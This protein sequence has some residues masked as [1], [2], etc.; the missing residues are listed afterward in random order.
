MRPRKKLN[1]AVLLRVFAILS[2]VIGHSII[3]YSNEWNWYDMTLESPFLNGLKAFINIFQMPLFISLSGY[4]FYY[5]KIENGKYTNFYSFIKNK[6][7]RLIVPFVG[8]GLLVMIPMRLL[9]QYPNY[10]GK[11]ISTIIINDLLLGK[12]AGNLWFLP[13]LFFIF[14][15]FY[16]YSNF[17]HRNNKLF[18]LLVFCILFFASLISFKIPNIFFMKNT[19]YYSL[20]FYL[21]FCL[22]PLKYKIYSYRSIILPVTLV[23]QF[24]ALAMTQ[25]DLPPITLFSVIVY[26]VEILSS[27]LSCIFFYTAF[28]TIDEKYKAISTSKNIQLIDRNS[29]GLYLFHSSLMYPILNY[30]EELIVNPILF[31]LSLFFIITITSLVLTVIITKIP[32]LKMLVGK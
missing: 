25:F 28:I 23:L 15:I 4:L 27:V 16:V 20:F 30:S 12:D 10:N 26:G 19:V 8:I 6:F 18:L 29:F 21:G 13:V 24:S 17:L 31:S 3:V 5:L 9:G 7:T 14:I 32:Y 22:Y 11:S 2:V 1:E